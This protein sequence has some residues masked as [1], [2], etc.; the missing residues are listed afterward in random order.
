MSPFHHV[1]DI[2]HVEPMDEIGL[3]GWK[4][5]GARVIFHALPGLTVEW[6]QRI[7]DCHLA[8]VAVLGET[9][10]PRDCPLSVAGIRAQV[11]TIEG[12]FAV[13]I[14]A[15]DTP[16]AALVLSRSRV[17]ASRAETREPGMSKTGQKPM[18]EE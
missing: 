6:L 14:R 3:T 13:E 16:A 7:V 8:R 12:G 10:A 11:R 18:K 17:L 2:A 9:A 4:L 15:V 1:D 5:V